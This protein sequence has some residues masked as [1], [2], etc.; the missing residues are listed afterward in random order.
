MRCG[1]Q[2]R[3]DAAARVA[4]KRIG[5]AKDNRWNGIAAA[6]QQSALLG[7]FRSGGAKQEVYTAGGSV[8][9]E[10]IGRERAAEPGRIYGNMV[11][12]MK[13]T[14]DLPD[15][16][17]IAAKKRAAASRT[18]LRAMFERGLRRELA[19]AP[20]ARNTAKLRRSRIRWV[21]VDGGLPPGLDVADRAAMQ[22]WLRQ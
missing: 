19:G 7:A 11:S 13:T 12:H 22:E 3:A 16:L 21:T 9:P 17:F 5:H 2:G 10:C 4:D 15:E 20:T 18:T 14:I 1:F 8:K 6:G